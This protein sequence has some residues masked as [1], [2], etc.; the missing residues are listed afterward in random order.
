MATSRTPHYKERRGKAILLELPLWQEAVN[1]ARAYHRSN[2]DLAGG[3]WYVLGSD[4]CGDR[5]KF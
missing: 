5:D 4:F 1:L 2:K 3:K